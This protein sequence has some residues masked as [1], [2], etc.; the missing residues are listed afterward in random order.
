MGSALRGKSRSYGS[1]E[2]GRGVIA[3]DCMTFYVIFLIDANTLVSYHVIY[4]YIPMKIMG[5]QA[6][7]NENGRIVVP[8]LIRK[9]M[10]LKLGDSVVM[11][12]ESGVLRIEPHRA[13]LRK[14]QDES[15]MAAIPE[16]PAPSGLV[17]EPRGELQGEIEEWLG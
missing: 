12:L 7:I 13:R 6:R 4:W 3:I 5:V 14:M 17:R 2:S 8:A 16:A 9:S 15:A 1:A 10:G 11:S